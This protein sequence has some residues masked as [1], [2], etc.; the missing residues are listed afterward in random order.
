MSGPERVTTRS[1]R[2]IWE[3]HRVCTFFDNSPG[4]SGF[5]ENLRGTSEAE[6]YGDRNRDGK[7]QVTVMQEVRT[8]L[9]NEI[10]PSD[11]RCG[12]R[13]NGFVEESSVGRWKRFGS[14]TKK[15]SG[16]H[17][18]IAA[19]CCD[20][21]GFVMVTKR[22]GEDRPPSLRRGPSGNERRTRLP[23]CVKHQRFR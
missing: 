14:E 12:D 19:T 17:E 15:A 5:W 22:I 2:E 9:R 18:R 6:A 11:R 13:S 8:P 20:Q 16:R 1:E 7:P 21:V 4:S 3:R 10:R 23:Q